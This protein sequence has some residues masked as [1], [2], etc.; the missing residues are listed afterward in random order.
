MKISEMQDA[1]HDMART[2]GWWA[3][4]EGRQQNPFAPNILATK[5]ALI[6]S[7]V[8]EALECARDG[9]IGLSYDGDKPIGMATELADI[10][11]RVG[12]LCGAL[13]IDLEAMVSLKMQYNATRTH[14]H[15]GRAF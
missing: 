7:E 9:E 11:I 14:R 8:S 1:A 2:K 12:D 5:L 6:H 4:S 3:E 10:V 13:G 15:G